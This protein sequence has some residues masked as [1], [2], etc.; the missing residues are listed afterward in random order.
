MFPYI[1]VEIEYSV[2]AKCALFQGCVALGEIV[3][4]SCTIDFG[5]TTGIIYIL[6]SLGNEYVKLVFIYYIRL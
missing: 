5:L 6:F 1:L 3:L 4:G 2:Y